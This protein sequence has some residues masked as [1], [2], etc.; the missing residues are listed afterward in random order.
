[1]RPR[2]LRFPSYSQQ[3]FLP[4]RNNHSHLGVIRASNLCTEIVQIS[5]HY[6][7]A[8]CT[9]ASIALP[10]FLLP[11]N[12]GID[13][14]RLHAIAKLVVRNLEKLIDVT[15]YPRDSAHDSAHDH[16]SLGIGVQGF[17]EALAMMEI[18]FASDD[19]RRINVRVFE[20]IYHAALES[21]SEL[22]RHHLPC[23]AYLRSPASRGT[24]QMDMWGALPTGLNDFDPLRQHIAQFGL[25]HTMLTAQMPTASSSQILGHSEG[26]EPY[27]RFANTQTSDLS[28]LAH[29]GSSC[30]P[31]NPRSLVAVM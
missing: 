21:S 7:I 13:Y 5:S 4:V 12:V 3:L 22:S 24:L 31:S 11:G 28:R 14:P 30:T 10:K 25:R 6:R 2:C 17:A 26:V 29:I 9:L 18:P 20:T 15:D 19:A 27:I 8:V 1:M 16:R 23:P